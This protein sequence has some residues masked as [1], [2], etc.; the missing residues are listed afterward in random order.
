MSKLN[1]ELRPTSGTC[2]CELIN[3][4]MCDGAKKQ[5]ICPS[6]PSNR[7]IPEETPLRV[8]AWTVRNTFTDIG[9]FV[10]RK[11]REWHW[12]HTWG[13]WVNGSTFPVAY[14]WTKAGC[15]AHYVT[16]QVRHCEQCGLMEKNT[17]WT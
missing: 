10:R 4:G 11:M 5:V 1:F 6:H 8:V 12:V 9:V 14:P 7:S 3:S 13:L 2:L 16:N 17:L 15:F